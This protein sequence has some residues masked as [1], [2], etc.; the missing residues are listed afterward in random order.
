MKLRCVRVH[1][2]GTQLMQR[3][4]TTQLAQQAD[5][6]VFGGVCK[7]LEV[8]NSKWEVYNTHF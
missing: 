7:E 4:A 5:L 8:V 6:G 1:R 3:R 2:G